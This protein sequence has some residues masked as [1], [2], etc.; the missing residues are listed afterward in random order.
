[1]LVRET[2]PYAGPVAAIDEGLRSL[3]P[4]PLAYVLV[5]AVDLPNAS[6]AITVLRSWMAEH[7]S[8]PDGVIAVDSDGRDQFLLGFYSV[9]ALTHRLSTMTIE[10]ASMKSLVSEL[11]LQRVMVPSGSTDDIDTWPDAARL[12]V[13]WED[14]EDD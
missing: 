1:M 14:S 12:G 10:H 4:D 3:D 13:T 2:P 9:S 7:E 8:L 11:R 6:D 5:L